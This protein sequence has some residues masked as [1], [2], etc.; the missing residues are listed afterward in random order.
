MR[1]LSHIGLT[2][3]LTALTASG[4]SVEPGAYEA[5]ATAKTEQSAKATGITVWVDTVAHPTVRFGQPAWSFDMRASKDLEHVFSFS[6]DDE[7]G[8]A[9]QSS[10]R[11]LQVFV[12]GGQMEHL[13]RGYRL[14]VDIGASAGT[15][16]QY[17]ASI[18]VEPRLARFHGSSKITLRK[19]VTPFVFG[20]EVRYR[21]LVGFADGYD[22]FAA[23]TPSGATPG[24]VGGAGANVAMDWLSP[25]LLEVAAD[26]ANELDVSAEKAGAAAHRMGGV[27]FVVTSL[28]LTTS[29]SPL[30][31]WPE[32]QCDPTVLSCLTGLPPDALDR[33][34]C[35]KAIAVMPCLSSIAPHVDATT[36]ATDLSGYMVDWYALHGADVTASGGNTLAQ[37]QAAVS[38]ANVTEV[39]EPGGDP[40]GHDLGKFR[41]FSHPDV[42]F[43]GSDTRWFGAYDR[44][45]GNR[46]SVYDFN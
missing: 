6:S 40:Q 24:S 8:E 37:A 17:F 7:L 15:Q 31:F 41:V 2:L 19:T 43:P 44:L 27:D 42:V 11:K 38:A 32:P 16:R 4:C 13:L 14:L 22:T 9:I 39:T 28:Q 10:K 12:D 21:N 3:A 1:T 33:S 29:T 36:F 26:D 18:R 5:D 35:G 25:G 45:T 34:S 30:S 20:T 23:T 46:E